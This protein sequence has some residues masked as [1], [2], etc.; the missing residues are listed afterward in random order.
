MSPHHLPH[1]WHPIENTHKA[2]RQKTA[3]S[4]PTIIKIFGSDDVSR[5]FNLITFIH[6]LV[7]LQSSNLP[8]LINLAKH[9]NVLHLQIQAIVSRI[10]HGNES[11]PI[12]AHEKMR[13]MGIHLKSKR[14]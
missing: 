6:C 4:F 1:N 14:A 3:P 2:P 10:M 13:D 5:N 11:P 8:L 12:V 9:D 7:H